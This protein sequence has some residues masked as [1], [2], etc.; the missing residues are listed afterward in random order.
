[1][2]NRLLLI[3]AVA[4]IG[5]G[6]Y[7][8]FKNIIKQATELAMLEKEVKDLQ[9][10]VKLQEAIKAL[11]EHIAVEEQKLKDEEILDALIAIGIV[12]ADNDR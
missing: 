8:M 9:S 4:V 11:K 6:G 2:F 10:A 3:A 7:L 12:R 1:M 5:F